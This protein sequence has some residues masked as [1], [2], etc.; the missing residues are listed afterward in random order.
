MIFVLDVWIESCEIFYKSFK[1]DFDK[2]PDAVK[3]LE[4]RL[5]KVC[6]LNEFLES[7][8]F[9]ETDKYLEVADRYEKVL[10]ELEEA[11]KAKEIE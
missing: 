5:D 8:G 11:L 7:A 9:I 6:F 3:E 10:D 4:A 2:R 1:E